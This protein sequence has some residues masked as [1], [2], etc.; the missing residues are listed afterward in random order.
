M[1]TQCLTFTPN[2][3]LE[4]P[5]AGSEPSESLSRK[6]EPLQREDPCGAFLQIGKSKQKLRVSPWSVGLLPNIPIFFLPGPLCA[7]AHR[8]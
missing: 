4:L 5:Q 7:Q 2:L 8:L 3:A 6:T 1:G